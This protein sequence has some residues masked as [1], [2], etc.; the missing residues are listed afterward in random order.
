[1]NC[2]VRADFPTPPLPTMITLCRARELWFLPLLVAMFGVICRASFYTLAN[3]PTHIKPECL[4]TLTTPAKKKT[5]NISLK[6]KT[7]KNK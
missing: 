3:T 7:I 4:H 2:R 6:K 5:E 1:M